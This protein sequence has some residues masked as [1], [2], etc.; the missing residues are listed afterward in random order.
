MN[1][2]FIDETKTTLTDYCKETIEKRLISKLNIFQDEIENIIVKLSGDS[3]K[4]FFV[5]LIVNPSTHSNK[6][7]AMASNKDLFEAIDI[8]RNK[9]YSQISKLKKRFEEKRNINKDELTNKNIL[10]TAEENDFDVVKIK[11]FD[12]KPMFLEE[13]ITQM[14]SLNHDFFIY[15]DA[16]TEK[17]NVIY[18]RKQGNY[19]LIET[20]ISNT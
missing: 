13:A 1:I 2:K 18:R 14:N 12:V 7:I 11:E 3:K 16:E 17:V 6:F 9:I 20:V 19:G 15:L 4:N 10:I 5:K 8:A